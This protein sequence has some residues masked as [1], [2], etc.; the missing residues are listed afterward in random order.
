[1][2]TYRLT[3]DNGSYIDIPAHDVDN[4]VDAAAIELCEP[5]YDGLTVIRVEKL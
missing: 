2:N 1:M 4:A 3:F 5:Q